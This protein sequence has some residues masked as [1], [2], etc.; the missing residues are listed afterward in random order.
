LMR[1]RPMSGDGDKSGKRQNV[2]EGFYPQHGAVNAQAAVLFPDGQRRRLAQEQI[3]DTGRGLIALAGPDNEPDDHENAYGGDSSERAGHSDPY[4]DLNEVEVLHAGGQTLFVKRL[5]LT[6][7]K[8]SGTSF[9]S[10]KRHLGHSKVR[11]SERSGRGAW[12]LR[13]IFI[14]HL[15]QRGHSIDARDDMSLT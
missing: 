9:V 7:L 3:R 15:L 1:R 11:F 10:T 14:R 8:G 5:T 2:D 6:D 13:L 12:L 4:S